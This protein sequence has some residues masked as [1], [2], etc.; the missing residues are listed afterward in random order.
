MM[1]LFKPARA[2]G[3]LLSLAVLAW[4]PNAAAQAWP[5]GKTV[6]IIVPFTAGTS[7]D[8][9]ARLMAT[10]F[11]QRTGGTFIVEN[12]AGAGGLIGTEFVVKSPPDGTTLV[13][14]G[15]SITTAKMLYKNMTFDPLVDLAPIGQIGVNEIV[16]VTSPQIGVKDLQDFVT[17]SKA[18]P[19]QWNYGTPGRG[20]VNTL[21]PEL[22][23]LNMGLQ[24]TPVMYKGTAEPLLA[25]I[26]NEVQLSLNTTSQVAQHVKAGTVQPLV[27]VAEK[28]LPSM[29]NL[30]TLPE[31]G[32][33]G[34]IPVIWTAMMAPKDTPPAILR[35]IEQLLVDAAKDPEMVKKV[36]EG[37]GV[38]LTGVPAETFKKTLQAEVTNWE[39]LF[40]ALNI[41]PE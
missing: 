31:A 21:V 32:Y 30:M 4:A 13:M 16:L 36:S 26:K 23:K 39:K 6:K 29:P 27:A 41:Q 7:L 20:V 14:S 9:T 15:A 24:L 18:N 28:R 38:I 33:K 3:A 12:K 17:K 34:F 8:A 10:Y 25:V 37:A 1:K 22:L 19:K 40:K 5:G 11:G 35:Q 2:L